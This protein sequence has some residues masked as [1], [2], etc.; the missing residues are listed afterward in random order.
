MKFKNIK[1]KIHNAKFPSNSRGITDLHTTLLKIYG[2]VLR[3]FIIFV[4]ILAVIIVGLDFKNNL[5][6]KQEIDSQRE[7][8]TRKLNYWKDFLSK[9]QNYPDAFF[10]VSSLEY[11]LG[12]MSQ[13]REYLEKG[14]ILDPNSENGRKIEGLLDK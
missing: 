14:L 7:D 2:K 4:F 10:Q 5:Q 1:K 11:R 12:N 13:A 6:T 8:L 9:R 3:V